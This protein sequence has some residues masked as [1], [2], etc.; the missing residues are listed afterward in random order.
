[1]Y[2]RNEIGE[3]TADKIFDIVGRHKVCLDLGCGAGHIAPHLIREN[4]DVLIQCDMSSEMVK[5]S[6]GTLPQEKVLF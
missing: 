2:I 3:R 1:M 6:Q 4:V 5:Q